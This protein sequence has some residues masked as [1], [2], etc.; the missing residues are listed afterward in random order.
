VTIP[1]HI[2][3]LS[4]FHSIV[5][6]LDMKS[7][8]PLSP[9]LYPNKMGSSIWVNFF[10]S[11]ESVTRLEVAGVFV[12]IIG[13]VLEQ[14]PEEMVRTVLPALKDLH[15]GKCETPGPFEKFANARRSSGCPLT[16]HYATPN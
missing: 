14:L 7:Y 1:H 3:R 5:Q 16:M 6:Q 4:A 10:C 9:W 12:Q 13:S 15:V 2:N 11:L 8:L